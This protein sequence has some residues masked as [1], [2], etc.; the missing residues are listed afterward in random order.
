MTDDP[1]TDEHSFYWPSSDLIPVTPQARTLGFEYPIY[2]TKAIWH[3]AISWSAQEPSKRKTNTD[4]RI[5]QLLEA[6]SA[7]LQKRLAA[8]PNDTEGFVYFRFKHFYW[9]RGRDNA[10][11]KVKIKIGCRIL[12]DPDSSAPW[13][14]ILDPD[15]D[16]AIEL[17]KGPTADAKNDDIG[18]TP[19]ETG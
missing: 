6:C 1:I 5:Y 17:K 10:K 13:M 2:V 7:G 11:K 8:D 14:L 12:L 4:K 18:D 15:Y 19:D 16:Y 3:K 9:E